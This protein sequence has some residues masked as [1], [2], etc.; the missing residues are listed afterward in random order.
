MLSLK[1]TGGILFL[2]LQLV[3]FVGY[4]D[5]L[6]LQ[7]DP[8]S[9]SLV[10]HDHFLPGTLL[11][12]HGDTNHSTHPPPLGAHLNFSHLQCSYLQTHSYSEILDVRT[13]THLCGRQGGESHNSVHP[14]RLGLCS[15][16]HF[17]FCALSS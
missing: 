15:S 12:C 8:V 5:F 16:R 4:C 13:S 3:I 11:S 1:P 6:G 14:C 17:N 7:M 10:T 2:L 9:S